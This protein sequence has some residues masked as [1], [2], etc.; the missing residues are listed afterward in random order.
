MGESTLQ[1]S[2]LSQL[3]KPAIPAQ[4]RFLLNIPGSPASDGMIRNSEESGDYIAV[5]HEI[6]AS[7]FIHFDRVLLPP[8]SLCR[9]RFQGMDERVLKKFAGFV[10]VSLRV[11]TEKKC[12]RIG[13]SLE[14]FI[15]SPRSMQWANGPHEVRFAP[16]R[17][18]V[19][20][21]LA[22]RLLHS[23]RASPHYS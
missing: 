18:F 16:P 6:Q 1:K 8:R 14:G 23:L 12:P 19:Y 7:I 21:G 3:G 11:S 13:E 20:C 5:P 2:P 10:L 15:R 17:L 9:L 22:D 4:C